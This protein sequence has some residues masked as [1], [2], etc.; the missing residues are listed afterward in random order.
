MNFLPIV[1][2]ELI[3]S[4]RRV[5]THTTRVAWGLIGILF[6]G[7]MIWSTGPLIAP[8]MLG[9]QIFFLL[10][11]FAFLCAFVSGPTLTADSLSEEK[12]EGTLGLLFLTGLKPHDVVLGKLVSNGLASIYGV[13]AFFPVLTIPLLLGGVG[14]PQVGR[15]M[16]VLL[17]TIFLSL[18]VGLFISSVSKQNRK[19][20]AA[21]QGLL[22]LLAAGLPGLGHAL[23][24]GLPGPLPPLFLLPSPGFA[25]VAA[26]EGTV[27]SAALFWWSMLTIHLLAWVFLLLASRIARGIWRERARSARAEARWRRSQRW[28]FGTPAQRAEHRRRTLDLNPAAWL[29][30]R[31]LLQRSAVLLFILVFF[32]VWAWQL[33]RDPA[34]WLVPPI[35]IFTGLLLF[36]IFKI[37]MA[38]QCT[39]RLIEDR[40]SG[41]LELLLTTPLTSREIVGGLLIATRRQ[42]LLPGA[43]LLGLVF[44]L[45][46]A[47]VNLLHADRGWEAG[48]V[49]EFFLVGFV[50]MVMF[51]ADAAT[52]AWVG[53]W[54]SLRAKTNSQAAGGVVMK[55]MLIPWV[56]FFG[57]VAVNALAL[58]RWRM[59]LL[60]EDWFH[61]IWLSIGLA[62][63]AA[64][65]LHA[66]RNLFGRLRWTVAQWHLRGGLGGILW[67]RLA[68]HIK[69]WMS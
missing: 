63:N 6:C 55:V 23:H 58:H 51:V 1:H 11:G 68:W 22:V 45:L 25:F 47:Q 18:A 40:R 5:Q 24:G 21:T 16:L 4:A 12:R 64:L 28:N 54:E 46:L 31:Y 32:V 48:E 38:S 17:N 44:L 36:G 42:F 69:K 29:D 43:L 26:I 39:R 8:A 50:G 67:M 34:S 13:I 19:A 59:V 15:V 7:L 41:A 37:W 30:H 57:V 10:S 14:L 62:V 3:V 35:T 65:F 9:Q 53:M 20:V 27:P 33:A 56:L 61:W 66:R 49:R 52:I 2:R 60:D